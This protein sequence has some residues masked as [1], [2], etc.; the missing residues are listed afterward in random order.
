M[1]LTG[2]P[3]Y[4]VVTPRWNPETVR[5]GLGGDTYHSSLPLCKSIRMIFFFV[6]ARRTC[7]L[8]S[9][10]QSGFTVHSHLSCLC[11]HDRNLHTTPQEQ[12]HFWPHGNFPTPGTIRASGASLVT[13]RASSEALVR[14][15]FSTPAT[16]YPSAPPVPLGWPSQV[17]TSSP[18]PWSWLPPSVGDSHPSFESNCRSTV[19]ARID[20]CLLV[21]F[22]R[23]LI[24][25]LRRIPGIPG[26]FSIAFV[27]LS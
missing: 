5:A 4:G 2:A 22:G 20:R 7:P 11:Y 27:A 21:L 10:A 25:L 26:D 1:W 9:R 3:P 16:Y 15:K 13:P 14:G 6:W 12:R 19:V 24:V 23:G 8:P 17:G 18:L